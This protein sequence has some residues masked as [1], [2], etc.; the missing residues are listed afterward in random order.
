MHEL[1]SP[2]LQHRVATPLLQHS[3]RH[4]THPTRNPF[5]KSTLLVSCCGF[6]LWSWL[7]AVVNLFVSNLMCFVGRAALTLPPSPPNNPS[8]LFIGLTRMRGNRSFTCL[9]VRCLLVVAVDAGREGLGLRGEE[10]FRLPLNTRNGQ[11]GEHVQRKKIPC[12]VQG[13]WLQVA[14][15]CRCANAASLNAN[16]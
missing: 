4:Q 11:V 8:D 9:S 14:F 12:A 5:W 10:Y 13:T 7:A 2:Y 1:G 15:S 16:S 6:W 3:R